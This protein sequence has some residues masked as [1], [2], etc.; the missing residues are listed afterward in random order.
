[1]TETTADG[2]DLSVDDLFDERP[3]P[4]HLL[5]TAE[6][7]AILQDVNKDHPSF[8]RWNPA[9]EDQCDPAT[10]HQNVCVDDIESIAGHG[11]LS[12]L[13]GSP[14]D[15][16]RACDDHGEPEPA[17]TYGYLT[18]V[19]AFY[20]LRE[21]RALRDEQAARHEEAMDVQRQILEKLRRR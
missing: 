7:D 3:Q 1:M 4:G 12:D 16:Q 19:A 15:L 14:E 18:T 20:L 21:T 13:F 2:E 6:L 8:C 9:K 17:V 11:Y 5:N 10:W